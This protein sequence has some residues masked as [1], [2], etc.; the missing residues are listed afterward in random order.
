MI[1]TVLR[2]PKILEKLLQAGL[3]PNQIYGFKKNYWLTV[4]G[5]M[6][7]KKILF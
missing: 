6:G 5:L 1:L 4:A 2:S 7:L 3:D